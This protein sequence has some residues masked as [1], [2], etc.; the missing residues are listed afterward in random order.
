MAE[1]RRPILSDAHAQSAHTSILRQL[2]VRVF[3]R[4]KLYSPLIQPYSLIINHFRAHSAMSSLADRIKIYRL[5]H[6][7]NTSF[8]PDINLSVQFLLNCSPGSCHGG[9]A[10][11]AYAFVKEFGYV[12][13]DTCQ[14]YMACSDDSMDGFCPFADTSCKDINICRTCSRDEKGVGHCTAV[15]GVFTFFIQH[16]C[17][18]SFTMHFDRLQSSRMR[19]LQSMDLTHTMISML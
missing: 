18:N 2:L 16:D 17:S 3:H 7:N 11:R 5:L 4:D 14:N 13:F 15:S 8:A 9:S 1:C 6:G 10:L 19:L 12:P